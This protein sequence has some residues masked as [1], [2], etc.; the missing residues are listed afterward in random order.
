[1]KRITIRCDAV[2]ASSRAGTAASAA[3]LWIGV[4]SLLSFLGAING[5]SY[6][7]WLVYGVAAVCCAALWLAYARSPVLSALLAGAGLL[8]CGVFAARQWGVLQVQGLYLGRALSG[9][10][11]PAA[12]DITALAAPAAAL[13]SLVLFCFEF[14][15]KSHLALYLLTTGLLLASPFLGVRITVW[16]LLLMV[17]FQI[18][19]WSIQLS[20][21]PHG[22]N[23]L[24]S[25]KRAAI[26]RN[27]SVFI[28]VTLVVIFAVVSPL[29][30]FFSQQLYN[31]AYETEGY[32]YRSLR[33]LSGLSAAPAADG[34]IARGNNYHTGAAQLTLVAD[35]APTQPLYLRGFSGGEYVGGNWE[36]ADDEVLFTRMTEALNWDNWESWIRN[37]YAS[38]YYAMA[39]SQP[40]DSP[41]AITLR[42]EHTGGDYQNEYA[43]YYSQRQNAQASITQNADSTAP[44][45]YT[46]S[47]FQQADMPVDWSNVSGQYAQQRDWYVELRNAYMAQANIIYTQVPTQ[48]VPRLTRLVRENPFANLN[49]I[50]A[51]ILY[52][53][54]SNARYSLTPGWAALNEDIVEN[55]LFERGQGYCVHFAATATLMYRLY[56]IP[57]RY[58]TGYLVSPSDFAAQA[59]GTW[60]AGVT[61]EAAHAWVEI[62]LPNYGWTPVEVTPAAN[63]QTA[64]AYPGFDS[65]A[66][67]QLLAA[68][69]WDISVPSLANEPQAAAETRLSQDGFLPAWRPRFAQSAAARRWM[70]IGLSCVLLLLALYPVLR[71]KHV[72]GRME[73]MPCRGIFARLITLLHFCNKLPGLDGTETDFAAQLAR[74]VPSI[75]PQ[76]AARLYSAVRAE[77]YGPDTDAE[78]A[79]E[80]TALALS[81]YRLAAKTL[82]PALP[83]HRKLLFK[84]V[85]AFG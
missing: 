81:L 50:T 18:V 58:A 72:L 5:V 82:Y 42:I 64:A 48:L 4:C 26:T 25:T 40:G 52:T 22:K 28:S 41:A 77:A 15:L 65:A 21:K 73:A 43:P 9:E 53:L 59:D 12:R 57:A 6:A 32:V 60:Q 75:A 76:D 44:W 83:P 47:Y 8:A 56:G 68:H 13:L 38:M 36:P 3:F 49:E 30:S 34:Q 33:N 66:F 2:G 7:A 11:M 78:T 61:D 10:T 85:Y 19:F 80:H 84:F 31:A 74:D 46:Y 70:M 14:L 20:E 1:M 79:A 39:G 67:A 17:V 69:D 55:F 29:A 54:H 24:F 63:G 51:F 23:T 35:A 71:R 37:V 27:S 16:T 45:G 62:F